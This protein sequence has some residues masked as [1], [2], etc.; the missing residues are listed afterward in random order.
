MEENKILKNMISFV[1]NYII[2]SEN[3]VLSW[4]ETFKMFR[5]FAFGDF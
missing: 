2:F 1:R 3:T 4:A 5:T